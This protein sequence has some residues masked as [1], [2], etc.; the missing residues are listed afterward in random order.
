M[1]KTFTTDYTDK[2]DWIGLFRVI[3]VLLILVLLE[4][5]IQA[6]LFRPVIATDV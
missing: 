6:K 1:L 3:R 2:T 5:E 4:F